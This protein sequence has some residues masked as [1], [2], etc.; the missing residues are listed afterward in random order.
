M[1]KIYV[2]ATHGRI[3]RDAPD[4]AFIPEDVYVPVQPTAY[5]DRLINVHGDLQ[6]KPKE[7]AA[8]KTPAPATAPKGE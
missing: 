1:P 6:V 3:A 5:I 2:R 8:K 4:G 7:S